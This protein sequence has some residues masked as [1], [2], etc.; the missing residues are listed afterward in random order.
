MANISV[1][2]EQA[3]DDTW[4]FGI[5]IEDDNGRSY[6]RVT[7]DKT[8]WNQLT[9]RNTNPE[10]LVHRSFEFL[11]ER[12]PRESILSEFNLHVINQYFSDYEEAMQQE[13]KT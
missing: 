3:T 5:D 2:R 8:Y 6:H 7:V 4:V 11:L 1:T 12:E 9:G 13:W 10:A